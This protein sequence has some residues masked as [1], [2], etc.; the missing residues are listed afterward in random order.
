KAKKQTTVQVV[1]SAPVKGLGKA[2]ELVSVKPAYAQNFLVAQ[3]LGKVATAE[4]LAAIAKE[5][6][7][8]AEAAAAAKQTALQVEETLQAVF[9]QQGAFVKKNVGPDGAIF[10]SVTNAEIAELILERSGVEVDKKQITAPPISSVGSGFA[11]IKLHPDVSV[12]L[13]LVVIPA[14][15]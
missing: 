9:G 11:E 4:T 5:R 8:L 6:E 3:G 10:G 15:L 1:L 13:K 14:S 2:G 7:A 12:K